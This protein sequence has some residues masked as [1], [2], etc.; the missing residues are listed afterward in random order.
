MP[1]LDD[2][3]PDA[4]RRPRTP[5]RT[6]ADQ[7]DEPGVRGLDRVECQAAGAVEHRGG[8]EQHREV[9]QA[10]RAERDDH[11][12]PLEAQQLAPLGVACTQLTRDFVSAEC[13]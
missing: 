3:S 12:E 10:G 5:A 6:P 7:P 9:D 1:T 11:V 2:D 8:D 13:R 4:S